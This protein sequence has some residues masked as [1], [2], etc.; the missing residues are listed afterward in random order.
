MTKVTRKYKKRVK[1][2]QKLWELPDDN[3]RA[4][5]ERLEDKYPDSQQLATY[6]KEWKRRQTGAPLEVVE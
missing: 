6:V 4:V 5:I 3:V 2:I 1:P